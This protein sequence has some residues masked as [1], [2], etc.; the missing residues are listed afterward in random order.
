VISGLALSATYP[1]KNHIQARDFAL[2]ILKQPALDKDGFSSTEEYPN[3]YKHG[4]P[5]LSNVETGP[6]LTKVIV[7]K[8]PSE[9]IPELESG[10]KPPTSATEMVEDI[11]QPTFPMSP[12]PRRYGSV[13][14]VSRRH[15]GLTSLPSSRRL[16]RL[17]EGIRQRESDEEKAHERKTRSVLPTCLSTPP[18][19]LKWHRFLE[20]TTTQNHRIRQL[21]NRIAVSVREYE[22]AQSNS[23]VSL[24]ISHKALPREL[25]DAFGHDPAAVTGATR[26]YQGW[27][28]VD[29]IYRR[30]VRQREV[31]RAFL[32]HESADMSVS[33]SVLDDPIS[34]LMLSLSELEVHSRVIARRAAEAEETLKSVQKT[35]ASVKADYKSTLS[36]TSVVYPEVSLFSFMWQILISLTS[37]LISSLWRRATRISTN[38][39]G[40]LVWTPLRSCWTVSLHFGGHME[41]SSVMTSGISSLYLYIATSSQAKRENT[42]FERFQV[43]RA[44]TG[45]DSLYFS[46]HLW[47]SVSYKS[48]QRSLPR[49]IT[50]CP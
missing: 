37:F 29:D 49:H 2:Q 24:G 17:S 5:T 7:S 8:E 39:F 40:N 18:W 46:W 6:E 12:D 30:L 14:R 47:P 31:F 50:N 28:A 32:S 36:H 11:H 3:G 4:A 34:S 15:G 44:V 16:P 25:L 38:R 22:S 1:T 27:R 10:T 43:A 21:L 33:E 13:D 45:W 23:M 48:V 35:H 41:N 20:E 19:L 42:Q 26:R 9:V